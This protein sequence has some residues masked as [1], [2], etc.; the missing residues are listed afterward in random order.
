M[1]I[2]L[3]PIGTIRSPFQPGDDIPIQPAY[4][5]ARGIVELDPT[6]REGLTDLE[7]FSHLILIY[8][9]HEALEERLT[10][11]PFKDPRP[12][13][14]FATRHPAWPN[15]LE[16]SVVRLISLEGMTLEVEGIDVLDATPL[17]DI[18]P[19]VP[20]FDEPSNVRIGWQEGNV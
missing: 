17:L 12:H 16:I 7:G 2:V 9:F 1:R 10:V 19:Y 3:R 5:R 4:S 11:V 8:H 15:H 13:G 14:V 6:Y 20:A 18:K